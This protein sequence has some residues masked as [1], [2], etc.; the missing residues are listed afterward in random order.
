MQTKLN[1]LTYIFQGLIDYIFSSSKSN[2]SNYIQFFWIILENR[3][4]IESCVKYWNLL[5]IFLY[6]DFNWFLTIISRFDTKNFKLRLA[7]NRKSSV[8][9]VANQDEGFCFIIIGVIIET[10][11]NFELFNW[12]VISVFLWSSSKRKLQIINF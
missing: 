8:L 1:A 12:F 5:N 4:K 2:K 9:D 11:E 6:I 7:I 3:K 10:F